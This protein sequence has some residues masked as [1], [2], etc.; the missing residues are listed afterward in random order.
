MQETMGGNLSSVFAEYLAN[1][2]MQLIWGYNCAILEQFPAF[3]LQ[4]S[5]KINALCSQ[6][7]IAENNIEMLTSWGHFQVY[8]NVLQSI[9]QVFDLNILVLQVLPNEMEVEMMKNW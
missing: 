6:N 3:G 9:A 7:W 1:N 4:T 8:F 5:W 2:A